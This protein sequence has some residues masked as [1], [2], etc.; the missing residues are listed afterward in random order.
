MMIRQPRGNH[1]AYLLVGQR[2][3]DRLERA[4]KRIAR[5]R[6]RCTDKSFRERIRQHAVLAV[7]DLGHGIHADEEC[8]QQRHQIAIRNGPGLVILMLFVPPAPCHGCLPVS[9]QC[10]K[11]SSRPSMMRGFS[12]CASAISP[13]ICISDRCVCACTAT[14]SLL[15]TGRKN[16]F[17]MP[18][19]YTVAVKAAAMP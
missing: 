1:A 16:R 17:A 7:V 19:P 4:R 5:R 11:P 9:P 15:A 14:L 18:M 13:S 12:P 8:Q 10:K 6:M 2:H 3:L